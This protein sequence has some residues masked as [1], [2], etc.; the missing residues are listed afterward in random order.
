MKLPILLSV[1]HA[2]TTTP[3]EIRS[4][5]CID[6][7]DLIRDGDEQAAGIYLPLRNHVIHLATTDVARAFVDLNRA[8]DDFR[9][10][11]VIKTHTCW[12]V[13]IY[14]SAPD[15]E[16]IGQL[17]GRY[18]PYHDELRKLANRDN[19]LVGIDCHTMAA[20]GPPVGPDPGQI[21]PAACV[22]DGEGSCDRRWT[23][24][25]AKELARTLAA[26]VRINDPFKGGY[27]IRRHAAEL[28]WLQLELSRGDFASIE[29]KA[30]AI[31]TALGNWSRSVLST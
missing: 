14:S 13:P 2:G 22:S 1:P 10:D 19:V 16:L 28:P 23:E 18:H 29:D 24:E 31:R 3:E 21:R 12:D 17:L 11:G 8:P 6:D 30:A 15:E 26:E 9:K 5:A 7:D 4:L 27:I 25:L 20:E